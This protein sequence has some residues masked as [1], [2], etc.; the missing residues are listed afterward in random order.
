MTSEEQKTAI[1]NY[2]AAYNNFD[3][4]GMLALLHREVL[5]KNVAGGKVNA[6]TVGVEQFKEL[7]NKS[8]ALFSS[9]HQKLTNF[10]L[11]GDR[12]MVE[13]TYEG[14]LAIDIPNGLN[15]G[16]VLRLNGR[17]EFEFRDGKICGITDYVS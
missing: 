17:S 9:R 2:I 11:L 3:I 7:A 5:F 8:K 13:I 15:A 1:Q 10:T 12:V 6:E 16:E 14:V 4:D